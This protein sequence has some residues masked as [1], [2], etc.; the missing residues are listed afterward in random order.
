MHQHKKASLFLQFCNHILIYWLRSWRSCSDTAELSSRKK[1]ERL[2]LLFVYLTEKRSIE[3]FT[4]NTE[5]LIV[6]YAQITTVSF[7]FL[8][9]E[10]EFQQASV[11]CSE[12]SLGL[13]V[14]NGN[15]KLIAPTSTIYLPS[16][17]NVVE[18]QLLSCDITK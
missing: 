3:M 9:T 16:F 18:L 14:F 8:Y 4:E 10:Q 15:H 13:I 7:I 1:Y 17:R 2:A 11:T 12:L 5:N 6:D